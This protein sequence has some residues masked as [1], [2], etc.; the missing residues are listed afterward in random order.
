[1]TDGVVGMLRPSGRRTDNAADNAKLTQRQRWSGGIPRRERIKKLRIAGF[2]AAASDSVTNPELL[3]TTCVSFGLSLLRELW[4]CLALHRAYRERRRRRHP[5]RVVN[6]VK[7]YYGDGDPGNGNCALMKYLPSATAY[8][9]ALN[10][11]QYNSGANCGRCVKLSCTDSRCKNTAPVVAQ[12]VDRCPECKH[13]DLV[14]SLQLW[15]AVTGYPPDRVKIT[16]DFI[17][18]DVQGGIQVCAK[19]GSSIDWLFVQP[20]NTRTGVQSMKI[21]GADAPIFTSAYY[22]MS[23]VLHTIPLSQTMVEMTAYTGETIKA[24]VSLT[25]NQF[26]NSFKVVQRQRRLLSPHCSPHCSSYYPSSYH[27]S[28]DAGSNRSAEAYQCY[29]RTN[30]CSNHNQADSSPDGC[31]VYDQRW[32][33]CWRLAALDSPARRGA[34]VATSVKEATNGTPS[35]SPSRNM[36]MKLVSVEATRWIVGM[37]K[38][39]YD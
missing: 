4:L 36:S 15:N 18:C 3:R 19:Q 32:R 8:H 23:T 21:N 9:V 37:R 30:P 35:V 14:M 25:A 29:K 1:M 22:F 26:P 7:V 20:G 31:P 11:E 39:R 13:G 38:V 16:W 24:T 27:S 2:T 33:R 17:D 6:H 10:N 12:I 28:L 34:S 5:S